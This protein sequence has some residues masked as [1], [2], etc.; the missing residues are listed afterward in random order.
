MNINGNLSDILE[1]LS[2]VPQGSILGSIIFNIFVDDLLLHR[3]SI[4]TH[5]Y[6]YDNALFTQDDTVTGVTKSLGK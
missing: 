6:A 2:G 1:I 4:Y 3:K 5:N